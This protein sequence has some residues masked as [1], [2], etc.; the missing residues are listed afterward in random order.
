MARWCGPKLFQPEPIVYVHDKAEEIS[1]MGP[2]GEG[3]MSCDLTYIMI[4]G[5][6]GLGSYIL[7]L[8]EPCLGG[9]STPMFE[10]SVIQW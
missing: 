4:I 5:N 1:T 2:T 7:T 6:K 9:R 8:M 3:N 10:G